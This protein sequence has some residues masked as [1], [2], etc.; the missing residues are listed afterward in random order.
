[1]SCTQFEDPP[2]I[3]WRWIQTTLGIASLA[4]SGVR[5]R[6]AELNTHPFP[7]LRRGVL[8]MIHRHC[9]RESYAVGDPNGAIVPH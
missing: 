9:N 7:P 4:A 5:L 2:L 8:V 6:K 3:S 1:M